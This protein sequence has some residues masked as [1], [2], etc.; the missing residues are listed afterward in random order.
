MNE[1]SGNWLTPMSKKPLPK[2]VVEQIKQAM[3]NKQ[4]CPGD[5]LPSEGELAAG[6]GVGKS[7]VREAIKMLEAF[8]VVEVIKGQGS[9]I[10][11]QVD[12]D[13]LN[14]LTFQLILSNDNNS[15]SLLELR[16]MFDIS[17]TT[18]AMQKATDM[19]IERLRQSIQAL[20]DDIAAG[21]DVAETDIGFH[22]LIY[23]ITGNPFLVHIGNTI[24]DLISPYLTHPN[25]DYGQIVLRD[26][27]SIL[28]AM[29]RKDEA[30]IKA[31]ILKHTA[32]WK[33]GILDGEG[34]ISPHKYRVADHDTE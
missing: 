12:G 2:Q 7:S 10:K 32:D 29:I 13:I 22:K 34:D 19:D 31:V 25:E 20:K 23:Q 24:L 11:T 21:N 9:R 1:N 15:A 30:Q 14:P 5:Y 33:T 26:H 28:Q 6:L 3:L 16:Q 17:A 4:L 18:L 27:K 8:G